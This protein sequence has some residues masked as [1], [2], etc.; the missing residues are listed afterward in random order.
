MN[1]KHHCILALAVALTGTG[2]LS[3]QSIDAI[4]KSTSPALTVEGMTD[5]VKTRKLKSGVSQFEGFKAFCVEPNQGIVY[6]KPITYDVSPTFST[7]ETAEAISKLVGAYFNNSGQTNQEAASTQWAIWE[8]VID[9]ISSPSL[10]TGDN[11]V[12]DQAT[13]DLAQQYLDDLDNMPTVDVVFLTNDTRQD[14][15]TTS[16]PEP[17]S[18]SL[19]GLGVVGFVLRRRR[20]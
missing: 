7:P 2:H 13:A 17:A 3:A 9:G 16:I 10:S 12:L 18:V 4:L 19:L 15:V 11:R 5:G 14:M 6:N 1:T 20:S 8:V